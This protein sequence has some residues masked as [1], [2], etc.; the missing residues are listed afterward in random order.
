MALPLCAAAFLT[1]KWFGA[2]GPILGPNG[3]L[4]VFEPRMK[5]GNRLRRD[6]ENA[7]TSQSDDDPKR[8]ALRLELLQAA[9]AYALSPCDATMKKNLVEALTAMTVAWAELAGCR[10][11]VMSCTRL[12]DAR[13][14]FGTPMDVRVREA[15][16]A[17]IAKGGIAREDFSPAVRN[18]A[19]E[20]R[21]AQGG[22]PAAC[23]ARRRAGR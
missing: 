17:A 13:M 14:A 6:W 1:V 21:V 10:D 3:R 5:E 20:F 9:N 4:P 23:H 12:D 2:V 15:V 16:G 11:G 22:G 18:L 19:L 7:K 8:N